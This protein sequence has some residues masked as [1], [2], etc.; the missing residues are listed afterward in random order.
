MQRTQKALSRRGQAPRASARE[1]RPILAARN[2]S[3]TFLDASAYPQKK[4][5]GLARIGHRFGRVYA[6]D[7]EIEPQADVRSERAERRDASVPVLQRSRR[8]TDQPAA[9]GVHER[10]QRRIDRES[11]PAQTYR[12]RSEKIEQRRRDLTA[13]LQLNHRGAH[14]LRRMARRNDEAVAALRDVDYVRLD[15]SEIESGKG[16]DAANR[17]PP[18]ERQ[19]V[20]MQPTAQHQPRVQLSGL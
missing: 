13:V 14:T 8:R 7:A 10:N 15:S 18:L 2:P 3:S 20:P 16:A 17:E 12:P 1:D 19:F 6:D 11:D 4:V 9:S 5:R